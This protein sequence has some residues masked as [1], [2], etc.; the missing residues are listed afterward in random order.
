MRE[1][2]HRRVAVAIVLA[3]SIVAVGAARPPD[4]AGHAIPGFE[5]FLIALSTVESGG[6]YD[7]LNRS[8]GAY[9]KYQIIP[10]SWRA[11]AREV[12]GNANARKTAANQEKVARYKIHQAWHRYGSWRVV[13]YWWLTG[14][15]TRNEAR[16]SGPAKRY[17]NKV[18]A[19]YKRTAE[20]DTQAPQPQPKP[21]AA[22][23]R[24][25]ET[26]GAL[27]WTGSW[28]SARHGSYAG[29]RVR[30]SRSAGATVTLAFEGRSIAWV[31][32]KGPTRGAA[33]VYVDG[34]LVRTVDAR[35]A[36]FRAV[37]TLFSA[38]WAEPG[39]HTIV[40]EVVGTAGRAVVAI[41]ELRVRR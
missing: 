19:V 36:R 25:Q 39:A 11:W 31:G 13:A 35:A 10:S 2:T 23:A 3:L 9:G 27:A 4:T 12:L 33:R 37:N 34:R 38:S 32:P 16:W 40:I 20:P 24:Y 15:S 26:H 28:A 30:W 29:D 5:R 21:P 14:R 7:A 22:A 41:D 18:M 17:V 1:P 8:S 6:R